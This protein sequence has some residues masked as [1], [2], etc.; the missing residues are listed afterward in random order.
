MRVIERYGLDRGYVWP[1]SDSVPFGAYSGS[2][3]GSA[4]AT[5]S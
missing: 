5:P 2:G 1:I 3:I 4:I